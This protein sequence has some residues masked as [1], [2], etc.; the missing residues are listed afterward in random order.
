M[1]DK[2][3]AQL[4]GRYEELKGIIAAAEQEIDELK[5]E[6]VALVPEGKEVEGEYGVFVVQDRPTWKYSGKHSLAKKALKE[7]EEEEKAKGIAKKVSNPVL[8]YNKK[9]PEEESLD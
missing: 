7:L 9:K 1:S 8:Y 6:I 3:P 5:P 4:F 2:T